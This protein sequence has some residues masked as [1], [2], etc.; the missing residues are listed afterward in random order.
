MKKT[1]KTKIFEIIWY[2]LCGAVALWGLTYTTLGVITRFTSVEA[3]IEADE[4]ITN[5]FKLGFFGWGLIILSIAAV[6]IIIVLLINAKKVDREYEKT[7]RRQARR[8]GLS[9]NA[10]TADE[11]IDQAE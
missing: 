3:L 2:S 8:Q 11:I 4:V 5:V 7:I 10:P 1:N 6:A 9:E